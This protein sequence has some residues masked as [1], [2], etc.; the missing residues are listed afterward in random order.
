MFQNA[1][2]FLTNSF[3]YR[4]PHGAQERKGEAVHARAG[5]HHP[6]PASLLLA[7]EPYR[8]RMGLL[9]TAMEKAHAEDRPKGQDRPERS[10]YIRDGAQSLKAAEASQDQE[11]SIRCQPKDPT[12]GLV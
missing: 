5:L 7:P 10:G 11:A 2:S 1:L 9:Q 6:V 12:Q 3:L 4:Q 8:G